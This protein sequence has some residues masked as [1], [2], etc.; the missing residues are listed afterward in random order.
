MLPAGGRVRSEP[1]KGDSSKFRICFPV[2]EGVLE[3]KGTSGF[4]RWQVGAH[5]G[6]HTHSKR[7]TD[8]GWSPF[9]ALTLF[10]VFVRGLSFDVS[11]QGA[12]LCV[13]WSAHSTR[14]SARA[15]LA[16][17]DTRP[18]HTLTEPSSPLFSLLVDSFRQ[19]DV[20][21]A[22]EEGCGQGASERHLPPCADAVGQHQPHRGAP[23]Q[24]RLPGRKDR[25]VTTKETA[26][27]RWVSK[28]TA[29]VCVA[30]LT[31]AWS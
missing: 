2:V 13:Q 23:L 3:K 24:H 19:R 14:H 12:L 1:N 10:F 29:V 17:P 9:S 11:I 6:N 5:R 20:V 15:P 21:L 26:G 22:P 4:H 8:A 18:V 25:S 7:C 30:V 27:R 31:F 28:F 16:A